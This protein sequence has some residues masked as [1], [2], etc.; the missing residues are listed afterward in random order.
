MIGEDVKGKIWEVQAMCQNDSTYRGTAERQDFYFKSPLAKLEENEDEYSRCWVYL[1]DNFKNK[2]R[3]F[4]EHLNDDQGFKLPQEDELT[5]YDNPE[6]LWLAYELE[7]IRH[8]YN[9]AMVNPYTGE[10]L[11]GCK[12]IPYVQLRLKL[13][14]FSIESLYPKT[15]V[16]SYDKQSNSKYVIEFDVAFLK[17]FMNFIVTVFDDNPQTYI[18]LD[19]Y[20][21]I[22]HQYRAPIYR[23]PPF[24]QKFDTRHDIPGMIFSEA[25]QMLLYHELAHIGGGHLDLKV[26][27]PEY[28]NNPD[29]QITEEDEADNQAICWLLGIRFLEAPSNI[30]EIGA[31]DLKEEL[32]MSIFAVYLLYT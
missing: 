12:K 2:L 17:A 20:K 19:G 26:A 8:A 29:V 1:S 5:S 28:G 13:E 7:H 31:D 3:S 9:S 27:D 22:T 18:E 6:Y 25:I 30:L 23:M 14:A 4:L 24:K 16:N 32:A 15:T 11:A 21:Y 10:L